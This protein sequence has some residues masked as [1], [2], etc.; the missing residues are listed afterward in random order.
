[1]N[2]VDYKIFLDEKDAV[3]YINDSVKRQKKNATDKYLKSIENYDGKPIALKDNAGSDLHYGDTVVYIRRIGYN[4][5]P[6][7]RKGKIVGESKTTIA[8][9]DE[10]ERK[11]GIPTGWLRERNKETDGKHYVQP[12]SVMLFKLTEVN[13]NSGFVFVKS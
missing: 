3:K 5:H 1:M 9:F 11:E 7:L 12:Q 13:T 2:R 6:E 8:I 10:D 4:G